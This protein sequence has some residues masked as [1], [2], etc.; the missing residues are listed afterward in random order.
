M[1]F[2]PASCIGTRV[3]LARCSTTVE[4]DDRHHGGVLVR[5][6]QTAWG[7]R[8]RQRSDW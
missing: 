7:V 5:P 6:I 4:H 1:D 2:S 3:V 8:S